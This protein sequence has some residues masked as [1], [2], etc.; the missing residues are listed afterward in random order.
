MEKY[1]VTRREFLKTSMA[2]LSFMYLPGLGRVKAQPFGFTHYGE[3]FGRLCY[4]EN[5]IGP[6]PLALEAMQQAAN[7]ANRYPDWFSET[8]ESHIASHHGLPANRICAG[9]GA[10]EITRL[11]ADAF[12]GPGDE[13]ILASPT[14]DQMAGEAAANGATVV[15]VPV[16]HN[17]VI[18]L[19]AILDAVGSDT[20]LVFLV[21]PNNPLATCFHRGDLEVFMNSL[22]GGV[23]VVV[24]EAY[25]HYVH[26]PEYESSIR[27]VSE[28]FPMIVIRTFSKVYGLAGARIGYSIASSGYTS[29][30]ASSQNIAMVSGLGHAAAIAALEDTQH[31]NDTVSLNDQAKEILYEGFEMLNLDYIPSEANFIM[32]NTGTSASTVAQMLASKGFQV[33]VGWGMPQ[34]IRVSTGT[35]EEMHRF[36]QALSECLR[37]N[38]GNDGPPTF[39]LNDIYPNPFSMQCTIKISIFDNEKVRLAIYDAMG[40]KVQTL[41]NGVLK[42]GIHNITWDGRDVHGRKA[43]SGVYIINLLQGEFATSGRVTL[44][45]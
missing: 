39:G 28:G 20:K 16:D 15:N 13:L 1:S 18:D 45:R 29:M 42:P 41:V 9:T 34:Y 25:H 21:N 11:V 17:H 19:E 3:T 26:S 43:A 35:I 12:L 32:F 44:V 2:G 36:I 30:I 23:V 5:P 7:Q 40:R 10:T 27:Y 22:P 33:R 38:I 6:S 4:N 31:V 24:D 14:Y 37:E 8:L